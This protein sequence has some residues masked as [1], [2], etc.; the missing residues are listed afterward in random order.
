MRW[1]IGGQAMFFYW[2]VPYL[3]LAVGAVRCFQEVGMA[4][5][6]F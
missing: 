4:F 5:G 2:L 1:R 3:C 6:Q